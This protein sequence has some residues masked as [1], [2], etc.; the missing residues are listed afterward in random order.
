MWTPEWA[1]PPRTS[2]PPTAPAERLWDVQRAAAG[3]T[4][5]GARVEITPDFAT[6]LRALAATGG[7]GRRLSAASYVAT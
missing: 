2:T 7:S 4:A 3:L 1:T 6:A 5:E